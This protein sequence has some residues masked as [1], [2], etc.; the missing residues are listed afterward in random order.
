ME[1]FFKDVRF[2]IRT[3]LRSPGFT[4]IAVLS[5]ALG[6]G[7][8][9]AIFS[10]INTILLKN[11]P[12]RDPGQLVLFGE[13]RGRGNNNGPDDGPMNLVSWRQ[14]Q[15]F[16]KSNQVLSDMVALNSLSNRVYATFS[17]PHAS[18]APENVLATL[19]SG[20]YFEVLGIHPA[21]G[22]FF[23]YTADNGAGAHPLA[24]LSDRFW[25]RRFHRDVAVI[26]SAFRMNGHEYTI[27]GVAP[28]SFFGTRVGEAPDFWMPL[29]NISNLAGNSFVD[30]NNPLDHFL[31]VIGRMKPG[32]TIDQA[33][34]NLN[35]A[36]QQILKSYAGNPP[37]AEKIR[38]FRTATLRLTPAAKGLSNLRARYEESLR[39]LM[40]VVA[41]VL[42]IACANVANLMVALGARRQRE[43]A[44]R[45]A[46]G[47]GRGRIARQL[48]TEGILIS[49]AAGLLGTLLAP[50]AG[51]ILVHLI[52]TGPTS[53]PLGFE[54]D[55]RVLAFTIL[56]SLL[57]GVVFS[58]A[59]ALRVGRTDLNTSLKEGRPSMATPR[60]ITFGRIMVV[61]Q[62]ALSLMLL[63][64]GG[65][66]IHSF[67]NLVKA[68][69]GFDRENVLLFKVDSASSG[70]KEDQRL[71]ALYTRIEEMLSR[72]PGVVCDGVAMRSFNEGR[73]MEYFTVPGVNVPEKERVVTLNFT[74]PAYFQTFGIP[75]LAGRGFDSRDTAA[76]PHVAVVGETFAKQVFGNENPIGKTFVMAPLT[77]KDQQFQIIG[78]ARDVKVTDVRDKPEKAAWIPL[79]QN[80]VYAGSIAVRVKGDTAATAQQVRAALHSI[81]PNLPIHWTTT[82]AEEVGDSLVRERAVA[83]LATFFAGLALLLSAIG[84][85]GTISFAVSNRT[86]EIGIRMALGAERVSVLGMVLSSAMNLTA[87]G[88]VIGI[89][90]ALIA[91]RIMKSLLYQLPT[92]DVISAAIA[93]VVLIAA[94]AI[95]GYLPARRAASVDPMRALRHE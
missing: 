28:G 69:T 42:L 34:A 31:H 41:L 70:Y 79:A 75:I 13:G 68:G 77:P 63:V 85:Y 94:A 40:G 81:E 82:L 38:H 62:V 78:I 6:I 64:A 37:D 49:A 21:Y 57:T 53:L 16:R 91:G 44:V 30:L 20:N 71:A 48:L 27:L 60:K 8:N 14:Y 29:T 73:W 47:A 45:L 32:V 26:G 4:A 76:A 58:L 65:M 22:R 56:I 25:E 2:G 5:L 11:L 92:F 83:Q 95:A 24:V 88:I 39:V 50:A 36:Y 33:N 18:H 90:L 43:M 3:L 52:S 72:L 54:L 15:D 80:P 10:F 7:A 17:G 23:D 86:S 55:S 84:L 9:T 35:V 89:P 1:T 59:P 87:A 67:D 93:M 46:I 66:L 61:G 74:T 19:V 51:Q 12:V